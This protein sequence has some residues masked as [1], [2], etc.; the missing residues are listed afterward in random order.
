NPVKSVAY[1]EEAAKAAKE[2]GGSPLGI[3]GQLVQIYRELGRP[4]AAENV[5]AKMRAMGRESQT[6][7]SYV[8]QNEGRTDDAIAVLRSQVE[9]PGSE[10]LQ[11][12][13]TLQ[14]IA[15]LLTVKEQYDDAASALSQ[16]INR[17]EGAASPDFAGMLRQQLAIVLAKSGQVDAADQL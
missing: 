14:H 3:Y 16:A 9:R 11:S 2:G 1:L 15:A 8:Y 12:A 6:A 17:V 7:L 4:D 10:P 5:I 13:S